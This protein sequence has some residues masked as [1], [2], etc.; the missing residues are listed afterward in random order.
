MKRLF[1]AWQDPDTRRWFPVGR[2]VFQNNLFEFVYTK[3]AKESVKFRPLGRMKNFESIYISDELFP[4][5]FKQ[6]AFQVQARV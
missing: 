5:F 2:L 4:P 6:G 3:G 1:L